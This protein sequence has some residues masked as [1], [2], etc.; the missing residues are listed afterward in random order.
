MSE[1]H[2]LCCQRYVESRKI[3][4]S[5]QGQKSRLQHT[6]KGKYVFTN[7]IWTEGFLIIL[8][9]IKIKK[10]K[11]RNFVYLLHLLQAQLRWTRISLFNWIIRRTWKNYT[12][13]MK[14]WKER[15]S[16]NGKLLLA[17]KQVQFICKW[18]DCLQ[19]K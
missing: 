7:C 12:K 4:I 6:S 15:N 11:L 1:K 5:E 19:S 10:C 8:K 14:K 17:F 2:E 13:I 16:F 3:H 9:V 18:N